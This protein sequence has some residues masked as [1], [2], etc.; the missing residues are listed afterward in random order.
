MLPVR[1]HG[2]APHGDAALRRAHD[3]ETTA[4]LGTEVTDDLLRTN[5]DLKNKEPPAAEADEGAPADDEEQGGIAP[6][7]RTF[8]WEVDGAK[9]S[10]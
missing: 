2:A 6:A 9:V 1:P 5:T 8:T 7:S 10:A 4:L 3:T